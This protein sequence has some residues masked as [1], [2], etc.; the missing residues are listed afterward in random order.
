ME[1]EMYSTSR[2]RCS[3]FEW[4]RQTPA[5]A[6]PLPQFS[7]LFPRVYTLVQKTDSL[8]TPSRGATRYLFL[9]SPFTVAKVVVDRTWH[10]RNILSNVTLLRPKKIIFINIWLMKLPKD[11]LLGEIYISASLWQNEVD[12]TLLPSMYIIIKFAVSLETRTDNTHY[13]YA[14]TEGLTVRQSR[15]YFCLLRWNKG[16]CINEKQV[17]S[18]GISPCWGKETSQHNSMFLH[19]SPHM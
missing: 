6:A 15:I 16:S 2:S 7:T 19:S 5:P 17:S 3:E 9:L 1:F 12:Q 14:C 4:Q 8:S 13:V 18:W 11:W 10:N